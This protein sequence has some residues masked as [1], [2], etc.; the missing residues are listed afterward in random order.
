MPSRLDQQI[1]RIVAENGGS[2]HDALRA[3]MQ[4]NEHLEAELDRLHAVV[5]YSKACASDQSLH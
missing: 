3:L 4:V 1:D 5:M 2:L